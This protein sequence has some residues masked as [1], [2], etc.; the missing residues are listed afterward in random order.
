VE[1]AQHPAFVAEVAQLRAHGALLELLGAE[2][3]QIREIRW[4]YR[5]ARL[6]RNATAVHHEL[7]LLARSGHVVEGDEALAALAAARAWEGLAALSERSARLGA[8]LNASVEYELAGYQANAACLARNVRQ[9]LP[10][11]GQVGLA[12]LVAEFVERRFL[13]VQHLAAALATPPS[14]L[15]TNGSLDPVSAASAIS[16]EKLAEAAARALAARALRAGVSYFLSGREEQFD[17]AIELLEL[18]GRGL[19]IAGT[20]E[21]S[22]MTTNLATLLPVM[23]GRSTWQTLA[24]IL[25]ENA[26]WQR[27]VRALARG[28][29]QPVLDSRSV[30]ELWPSQ[31]S[32]LEG[33]LLV[34]EEN[35]VVRMPTSAGKTR[36]AEMAIVHELVRNPAA[37]CLYIA[38]Y[39]ALASEIEASFDLLLGELGFGATAL[40][41]GLEETGLEEFLGAEEQVLVCTP[42]KADLLL[43]IHPEVI[44]NVE[45]IV[46]DEGQIVADPTRG[47]RYELLITRLRRRVPNARL[48]FLS[49]VVPEVTLEDFARWLQARERDIVRSAWRPAVQRVARF[50]WRRDQGTLRFA[51]I[52]D[53]SELERFL[54]GL[55]SQEVF[56]FVNP[57]TGR[58]NRRRFPESG[59]KSQVAAALA[60]E[61][62]NTGPVLVFCSQTNWAESAA[63]A[64]KLRL[65]Y[66]ELSGD[67]Q[68]S[69]ARAGD[70][71][72]PNVAQEWLGENHIATQLLN[73]GIALHHGRLPD[74]VRAAVEDDVRTGRLRILFATNT[75]A[76]GVNLPVRTVVVHS[77][78]RQGDADDRERISAR[79]YWNIAGRAGRA[80]RETD[81]LIVHIALT[82]QDDRDFRHYLAHRD[83]V[84]AVDSALYTLLQDLVSKRI[85]SDEAA[86]A[87]DAPLLA[88]L[89]EEAFDDAAAVD[90]RVRTAIGE[91]FFAVQARRREVDPEPLRTVAAGTAEAIARDIGWAQLQVFSRTGLSSRSCLQIASDVDARGD[92]LKVLLER[93]AIT[94][95]LVTTVLDA[96]A[97]VEEMQPRFSYPGGYDDLLALWRAGATV[98]AIVRELD[99]DSVDAQSLSVFLEDFASFRLPWGTHAYLQIAANR[100]GIQEIQ[101]SITALPGVLRYGVPTAVAAW[102]MGLGISSRR[103]AIALAERYAIE[104]GAEVVPDLR[105][106]LG[107]QQ[108]E[109][110]G[111]E[112]GLT[113][114]AL[115]NL[116]RVCLRARRPA[117]AERLQEAL[118]PISTEFDVEASGAAREAAYRLEV[119]EQLEAVRD[120]ASA[121]D[122]NLVLVRYGS[123]DLGRLMPEI[124][125]LL[126]VEIDAGLRVTATVDD[127]ISTDGS[128]RLRVTLTE[129]DG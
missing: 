122:R 34:D 17:R 125:Q 84:E 38:P 35:K 129:N 36:V 1:L 10:R 92:E 63:Q 65:E 46:L 98:P 53:E 37:R 22:N 7:S 42:E 39:R 108:I 116:A 79:D 56:E 86:A 102:L 82:E 25:P 30:S 33:G 105:R 112:L 41:G 4:T 89:V 15:R 16:D 43:R 88:M 2:D 78:W 8:L 45:L 58:I 114:Q 119:G 103:T 44:A 26:R 124:G 75:L 72:A 40:Q 21:E 127:R 19:A 49:A 28:L 48:L 11:R 90:E 94:D 117:L 113:G 100:F 62:A 6:T 24:P 47:A 61:F 99:D 29:N 66:G 31:L 111:D 27:Y 32:A 126:A 13:R 118:L 81:G 123:V 20:V 85:S 104:G 96:L 69:W 23:R 74:A 80:G 14:A 95:A 60:Y 54:P 57:A 91:S 110:L 106:W 109:D 120:Y 76:Q 83:E 5:P 51:R 9:E 101:P 71:L 55:V 93:G 59:N 52:S 115:S 107:Q 87:L 18:S 97:A 121:L 50:D 64:L 68:P 3:P 67:I 73:A 70:A 128:V 77:V 12:G